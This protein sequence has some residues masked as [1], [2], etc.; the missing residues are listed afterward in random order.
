MIKNISAT[1]LILVSNIAIACN[2]NK[3]NIYKYVT[4]SKVEK[5]EIISGCRNVNFLLT[6]KFFNEGHYLGA[7][8][9]N[10][11]SPSGGLLASI[12]VSISEESGYRT[13]NACLSEIA[14]KN[15][16]LEFIFYINLELS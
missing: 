7:M 14:L 10:I 3:V 8:M 13:A 11:K 12:P 5:T 4:D 15:S 1:I 6:P 9:V 16:E 2:D